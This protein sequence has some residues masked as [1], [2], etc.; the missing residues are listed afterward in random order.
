[1]SVS[2]IEYQDKYSKEIINH[3]RNIARNEFAY[4]DWEN[5][6]AKMTFDKYKEEGSKFWIAL[7]DNG[8]IIG[9][10]GVAK[11]SDDEV[12]INNLHICSLI[13]TDLLLLLLLDSNIRPQLISH[14]SLLIPIAHNHL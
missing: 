1:M 2:I 9:T 14:L 11:V 4:T 10:I 7:N 12:Y 6:F 3:I 5:Y 13:Y 8:K